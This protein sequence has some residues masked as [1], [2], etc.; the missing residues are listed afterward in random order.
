M[1]GRDVP[2]CSMRSILT[3]RSLLWS[4]ALLAL[5]GCGKKGPP[6]PYDVT[7]PEPISDLEGVVREGKVHIRWSRPREASDLSRGAALIGF[8]VLRAEDV[9][10]HDWCDECPQKLVS[11]AVLRL[12][13]MDNFA[14]AAGKFVY[15]DRLVS[16]GH[17][18]VYQVIS[19]TEKGYP[20]EP[21]NKAV[22]FWDVPPAPPRGFEGTAEDRGARLRWDPV[23][24]A[25]GY[26]VYRREDG[27]DFGDVP[28]ATV[29][30]DEFFYR[31]T[32]LSN[33]VAYHF[34]VRAIRNVVKTW[35]EGRSSE[36]ISVIPQDLRAPASPQ[37][38]VAIPVPEGIE[39]SWQRNTEPDL[40]GYNVY[41]RDWEG[42]DYNRL[43]E[44][45]LDVTIY[46]DE[47][48]EL[49]MRYEYAVTGVD[50]SP[51]R[52]ESDFSESVSVVNIR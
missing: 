41:R 12:D 52:N 11:V 10:T 43:N 16:H 44:L 27:G 33:G 17:V 45:P 50:N 29:G 39:L 13:K 21:S 5:L 19:L 6:I 9:L 25:G 3:Y 31:D 28:V 46:V 34:T 18:Y 22:I 2:A 42:G 32:D 26:R 49:G 1:T 4:V 7:V 24:G 8:E 36:E 47:T 40:L 23:E 35:V 37:G 48:A 38:L 20:S 15:R 51:R 30:E 14:F